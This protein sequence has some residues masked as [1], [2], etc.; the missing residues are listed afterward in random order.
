[1]TAGTK[2]PSP[3]RVI[4]GA[5]ATVGALT[6]L[7]KALA[8]AKDGVV[9]NAFG[10]SDGMDAFVI[11]LLLPTLVINVFAGSLNASYM[12][13][14]IECRERNGHSAAFS[15]TQALLTM[16]VGLLGI[17]T[18]VLGLSGH[19]LLPRLA[20]GFPH[21]KIVITEQLFLILLPAVFFSGLSTVYTGL[22]NSR[23]RFALGAIAP[24]AVPL[25]TLLVVLIFGR[26]V[27]IST[28]AAGTVLG[29][30]LH[31]VL[32]VWAASRSGLPVVP[33]WHGWSGDLGRIA[34]QYAAVAGGAVLMS[35]TGVV[36]Q[37]IASMLP[38]GSVAA[39]SYGNK[40]IAVL[41]GVGMA[42]LGTAVLPHFSRMAAR[43]EWTQ[44]ESSVR[45]WSRTLAAVSIPA[46]LILILGSRFIVHTVFER[47]AFTSADTALVAYIQ[48]M[49]LLQVPFY[50]LGLL[51][52]R[53]LTSLQRNQVLLWGN[54]ISLPLNVTLDLLLMRWLGPGGIALAT[55]L[56]YGVSCCYLWFMVRRSLAKAIA[57]LAFRAAA[58]NA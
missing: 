16:S 48:A 22:L 15:L 34:G 2:R 38:H 21:A 43:A 25:I 37:A 55:S 40:L 29:Y 33:R 23:E 14:L 13:V 57:P 26:R 56:V 41:S 51:Y 45:F 49:Y 58:V 27:G 31:M 32:V 7:A 4:F 52:V 53:T 54:A 36:D 44:L 10:T 1:M 5:A 17:A 11:A 35:S 24:A 3:N 46:T 47:G 6:V 12:S 19:I 9:A 28:L 39:L 42:A 18:I 20:P 50:T 30:G 8:L